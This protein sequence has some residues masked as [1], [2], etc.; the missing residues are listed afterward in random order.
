LL[1]FA[2]ARSAAVQHLCLHC[3]YP[4]IGLPTP[5]CPECGNAS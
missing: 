1:Q 3:G 5:V 2:R 4:R